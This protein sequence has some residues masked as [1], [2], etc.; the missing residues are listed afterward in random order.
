MNKHGSMIVFTL[1]SGNILPFSPPTGKISYAQYRTTGSQ[2]VQQ[3][4][5]T[6]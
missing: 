6:D 5:Y 4:N 2:F 1:T 3:N